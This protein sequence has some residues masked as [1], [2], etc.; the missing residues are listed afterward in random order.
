[1]R[2]LLIIAFLLPGGWCLSVTSAAG[3]FS[4]KVR[5]ALSNAAVSNAPWPMER[6]VLRDGRKYDGYIESED[7]VF[8]HLIQIR[9]R[10]GQPM[11]LVIRTI[12]RSLVEETVRLDE[13]QRAK[14]RQRI[15]QFRNR[16]QIEKGRESAIRLGL[17]TRDGIHY[18]HYRGKWFTFDSNAE[19]EIV[20]RMIVRVDQVFTAYRQILLPR[21]EPQR[22]LRVV[23]LGSMHDYHAYLARL[24]VRIT[25]PA[26]FVED[27]NL[28]I[29]GS[30]LARYATRLAE[31]KTEHARLEADLKQLEGRLPERLVQ[32]RQRMLDDGDSKETIRRAL[33][34]ERGKFENEI[35]AV[36][37]K[38]KCSERRNARIFD[39]RA[40]QMFI[41]LYHEAFHAYLENY[42]YPHESHDVPRWLNEGLATMLEAGLLESDTLRVDAPNREA[43]KRL[44]ADL[45][46][47]T[48][49]ELKEFLAGGH[50]AFLQADGADRHYACA[51]GL[52]Y[53]L[54]FEKRLLGTAALEE[55]VG[56]PAKSMPPVER[57][58]KLVGMPL[59]EFE[60]AWR[61][62]VVKLR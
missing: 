35:E 15:D 39:D 25:S 20:R 12:Q 22:P 11:H 61:A 48:P 60:K 32:L 34:V 45:A 49:L 6:V 51:W 59:A 5:A 2:R 46:G 58:E 10:K 44:Q 7:D 24:N 21:T 3:Q 55:Y 53:Y 50:Q 40:R 23:V 52:V 19:E 28:V 43:L 36:R 4:T 9:R 18:Q 38:M 33:I 41:R 16:A 26:C 17:I 8:V 14:L 56:Q 47:E 37:Y 29:A 57:F 62:Y 27:D 42:V 54:T 31:I 1:M 13:P 30:E